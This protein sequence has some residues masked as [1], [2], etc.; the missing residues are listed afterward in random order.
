MLLHASL[1]GLSEAG[2]SPAQQ[3]ALRVLERLDVLPALVSIWV[4]SVGAAV[5]TD[6]VRE[7]IELRSLGSVLLVAVALLGVGFLVGGLYL[8]LGAATVRGE[9]ISLPGLSYRTIALAVRLGLLVLF[10]VSLAFFPF[11]LTVLLLQYVPGLGALLAMLALSFLLW[12]EFYVFFAVDGL[13][14]TRWGVREAVRRTIALVHEHFWSAVGLFGLYWVIVL[15]TSIIWTGL[16]SV[17]VFSLAL[18]RVLAILGNA[19]VGT[20]VSLA[21]LLYVW[22]R[23]TLHET[24]D[25]TAST[26]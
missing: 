2:A 8:T 17:H 7:A 12:L 4:P 26:T 3:D 11:V 24:P 1:F 9:R 25:H 21:T 10:T 15:G 6:S 18:G 23:L 14:L 5:F 13:A 16:L 19:Y 20:W 22:D